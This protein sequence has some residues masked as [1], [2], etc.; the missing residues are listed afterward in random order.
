LKKKAEIK[1]DTSKSLPAFALFL[2]LEVTTRWS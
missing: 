1:V 2:S